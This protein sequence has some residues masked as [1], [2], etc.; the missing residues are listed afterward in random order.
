LATRVAK[1]KASSSGR[2]GDATLAAFRVELGERIRWLLDLFDSRNASAE[3]AGV[4]PEHLASYI[5][6]RAKPPFELI[7]RL[8]RAKGVS[9]D[10]IATGEGERTL[11]P[12]APEGFIVIPTVSA[13]ATSGPGTHAAEETSRDCYAF[14]RTWL[15][16]ATRAR[17]E[18][19][20]V[21]FNRGSANEPVIRDGE[22][23]LVDTSTTK[24]TIDAFYIFE[25]D[26]R[27]LTKL[28][29]TYVDGRVVLKTRNPEFG[30]QILARE[31]A[32]RLAVYGRVCWRAGL[33]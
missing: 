11:A 26:G 32:A 13:E 28:S 7:G 14:S 22:A 16:A 2:S 25:T 24:I 30:T 17:P 23:M 29:E 3:I 31:E 20:R 9:L 4:T 5:A 15:Q 21:I 27:L 6:G 12:S 8:A 18:D 33:L 19:L 1:G 10:W